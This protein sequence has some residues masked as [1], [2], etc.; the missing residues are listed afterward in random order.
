MTKRPPIT[1]VQPKPKWILQLGPGGPM[2]GLQFRPNVFH[3]FM[4]RLLLGWQWY[5][6]RQ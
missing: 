6:A 1:P 3:V 4:V 2:L 5:R